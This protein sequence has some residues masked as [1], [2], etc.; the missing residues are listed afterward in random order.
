[1]SLADRTFD[2]DGNCA[3]VCRARNCR[4]TLP[5]APFIIGYEEF[6]I[7]NPWGDVLSSP[8]VG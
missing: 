8:K 1:M 4:V 5:R 7:G 3:C 6:C 2:P